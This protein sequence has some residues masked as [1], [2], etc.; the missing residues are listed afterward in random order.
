MEI[1]TALIYLNYSPLSSIGDRRGERILWSSINL[2]WTRQQKKKRQEA[3]KRESMEWMV[4]GRNDRNTGKE[5]RE[6]Q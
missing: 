1:H 6:E 4:K 2:G 3:L 5:E